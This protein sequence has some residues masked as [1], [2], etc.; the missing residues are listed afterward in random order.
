MFDINSYMADLKTI[1]SYDSGKHNREGIDQVL[2]F[3]KEHFDALSFTTQTALT[4]GDYY[5]PTLLVSNI[6][7]KNILNSDEKF[8]VLFISH[9]D[10]V[11]NT[12]DVKSWPVTID[13]NNI[14][15]G[16]GVIDCKGGCLLVYT[17]LREMQKAGEISFKFVAAMNSDEE[18]GSNLSRDYFEKLADR[19]TYCLVFEPGRAG[20]E[21][22]GIRK[23]GAKYTV[24]VHGVGGHSGADFFKGANAIVELAKW[25]PEFTSLISRETETTVN[26]AKFNGGL[27][28][29]QTPDLAELS[30]RL[31]YLDPKAID[32]MDEIL[33][34]TKHPFDPRCTIEVHEKGMRR[35]PMI[36]SENTKKLFE[37]L[38]VAGKETGVDTT[39]IST[40][41]MS[42]G[43]WVA[44]H[45]VG[46][47]DGCGPCGDH[48]HTKD[49]CLYVD[50]VEP[51][52][53]VM[54][55]LLLNLFKEET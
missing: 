50:S 13:E 12:E 30:M 43:N 18:G 15:H 40:G 26:I 27:D 2:G 7:D 38:D 23:G 37:C 9:M 29:G 3:F 4:E 39:W 17:I 44:H 51:R 41:G 54:R 24:T 8:D 42:D 47:L 53:N 31:L 28:N 20:R 22:V 5:A 33:K 49:E 21:F 36:I 25:V 48:M 10:T 11:F 32:Q 52:F 16:P 46:T 45:G 14:A 55:Q 1:C 34:K 35:P 6:D 19:A